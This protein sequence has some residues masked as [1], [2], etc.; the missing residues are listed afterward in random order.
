M[1][2]KEINTDATL[3][4]DEK[5]LELSTSFTKELEHF[6]NNNIV[7]RKEVYYGDAR[8][9]ISVIIN[10]IS[11]RINM[12]RGTVKFLMAY[13]N[14]AE[15]QKTVDDIKYSTITSGNAV[16]DID[17]SSGIVLPEKAIAISDNYSYIISTGYLSHN[18]LRSLYGKYSKQ[19]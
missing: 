17:L 5:P 7:D 2:N 18:R 19:F 1:I 16:T 12:S 3:V 11:V 8:N 14:T 6:S 4:T 13:S 9:V 15:Y 10:A